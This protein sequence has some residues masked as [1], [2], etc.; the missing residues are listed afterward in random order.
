MKSTEVLAWEKAVQ[1][2]YARQAQRFATKHWEA[3]FDFG[4][5]VGKLL[6]DYTLLG[7]LELAGRSVL[8]V[9][10]CEPIDEFYFASRVESWC[11]LD[12]NQEV[13]GQARALLCADLSR[14]LFQR[15]RFVGADAA[16]LPFA[17]ASFDVVVSFSTIDHIPSSESRWRAID[18]MCRL[19]KPGGHLVLTLPNKVNLYEVSYVWWG[20]RRRNLVYGYAVCFW[21]WVVRHALRRNG[22]RI[23]EFT[24]SAFNPFTSRFDWLLKRLRLAS[25]KK[26]LGARMGF[27]AQRV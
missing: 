18:E 20:R 24:S 21:P 1:E 23:L 4:Y 26:L 9:G 17:D 10:C 7:R 14:E 19:V 6:T 13:L 5:I 15:L 3:R 25:A 16:C 2:A 22:M 11:A 27:L 8:N 12:I